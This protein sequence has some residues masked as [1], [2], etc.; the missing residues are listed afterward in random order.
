VLILI[1]YDVNLRFPFTTRELVIASLEAADIVKMNNHE[2]RQ[3]GQ[4]LSIKN[5][6]N[7]EIA[8]RLIADFNLIAIAVTLGENGAYIF[9]KENTFQHPGFPVK[10]VD[11][12][13]SGDAFFA[14]LICGYLNNNSWQEIIETANRAGANVA[15]HKGAIN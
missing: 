7:E 14:A 9:T 1:F 6:N 2:L 11:A 8:R 13:G 10:I 4:W 12:V 5:E 3:I 15:T